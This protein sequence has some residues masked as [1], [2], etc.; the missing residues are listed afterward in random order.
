MDVIRLSFSKHRAWFVAC[1]CGFLL[2][3][4]VWFFTDAIEAE[5]MFQGMKEFF[6]GLFIVLAGL[7]FYLPFSPGF[8]KRKEGIIRIKPAKDGWI[9][10][11][12]KE[13]PLAEIQEIKLVHRFIYSC[14]Q[15]ETASNKKHYL[16]TY[17]LISDE[18]LKNT[19]EKHVLPY[20]AEEAKY[21]WDLDQTGRTNK[22]RHT[23][24]MQVKE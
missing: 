7:A 23:I 9:S 11:K 10:A 15:V 3:L 2:L 19:L 17:N 14:L 18:E 6:S 1:V 5:T 8:L 4:S 12:H 13:I 16:N 22:D 24:D 20:L 21:R